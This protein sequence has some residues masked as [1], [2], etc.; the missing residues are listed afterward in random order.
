MAELRS[1]CLP[2]RRPRRCCPW[3]KAS[4]AWR[5]RSSFSAS[6]SAMR[7]S[8]DAALSRC[9]G[10]LDPGPHAAPL[11]RFDA[12]RQGAHGALTG[13]PELAEVA[14]E[15]DELAV[16]ELDDAVDHLVEEVAVVGHDEDRAL[17]RFQ[18]LLDRLAGRDVE[19]VC[20]LVEHEEAR[21]DAMRRASC[22]RFRSPP[23]R[24]ATFLSRSSQPNRKRLSRAKA[25]LRPISASAPTSSRMVLSRFSTSCSWAA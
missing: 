23:D 22:K 7:R 21:L 25:S 19:V 12:A 3:S 17:V 20:R 11:P 14:V 4:A 10:A 16:A 15:G 18:C 1:I 6:A 2:M 5:S 9:S 13:V 8:S 24:S